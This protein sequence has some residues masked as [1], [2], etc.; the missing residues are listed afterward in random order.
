[1]GAHFSYNYDL[2]THSTRPRFRQQPSLL[3]F[4]TAMLHLVKYC[5][6]FESLCMDHPRLFELLIKR[7]LAALTILRQL[8]SL[9]HFAVLDWQILAILAP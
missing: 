3:D 5:C 7:H 4:H 8:E 6:E 2:E 1:M 9:P